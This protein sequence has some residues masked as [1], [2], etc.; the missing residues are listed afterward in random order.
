[1]NRL[2]VA[3]VL[4]AASALCAAAEG[5]LPADVG[6]ALEEADRLE[7]YSL[8]PSKPAAETDKD[9]FHGYKVLGKTT[10]KADARKDLVAAV[11]KGVADSDGSM[12][13]CFEPRHGVRAVRDGKTYDLVI[14]FHCLQ[15]EA[16]AGDKKLPTTPTA[17]SPE[18]AL[19]GL[20]KDAGVPLAPK[21]GK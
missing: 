13:D 12:A 5:K 4:L 21:A 17:R 2:C 3:A 18:P 11:L 20:L 15:I 8:D 14:C 6:K 9:A 1:M 7:L 10:V 19:D 16:Y